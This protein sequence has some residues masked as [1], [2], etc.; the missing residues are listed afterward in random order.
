[1]TPST[2]ASLWRTVD[3]MLAQADVEGVLAHRLAPLAAHRLRR[4]GRP[5]P[6]ALLPEDKI[7]RAAVMTSIP[8]LRRIRDLAE[9]P[10]VLAKGAEVAWLYPGRARSFSDLDVLAAGSGALHESLKSAGFVEVADLDDPRDY[11]RGDYRHLQPLQAPRLWLRVEIHRLP[12]VPDWVKPPPLEEVVEAAVP[13][14]LGV[15]GISAPHPVHHALMLAGHAWEDRRPL[16][17][18][19]DL[20]DVAAVAE[21]A[22]EA[23][24]AHTARAWGIGKIWRTTYGAASAL[25][26][27]GR[28]TV[29]LRVLGRHLSTVRE[30][31]VLD[32]HLQRWLYPFWEQP[33]HRALATIPGTLKEE[34]FSDP[35]EP[36]DDKLRRVGHAL[37]HPKRTMSAQADSRQRDVSGD[38]S[39]PD[40][41]ERTPS[42][43]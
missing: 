8:L 4:L 22:S 34:L 28:R 26:A 30:R 29:A 41:H 42:V 6:E 43:E 17:V 9:G 10:L 37:G 27:G 19:R 35:G 16:H 11:R 18:L 24:L 32:H 13:S 3:G 20:I 40:G 12:I 36:W 25:L 31:S 38:I 7:A 39:S 5:V 15:E 21:H 33:F 23:E 2:E 14:A 1:M